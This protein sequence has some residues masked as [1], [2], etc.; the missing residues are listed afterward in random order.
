MLDDLG[1]LP[2]LIWHIDRYQEQTGLR[3]QF[4][5]SDLEGRRYPA[6]L[7]TAVY[8]IVQEALTNVA[9]HAQVKQA[10][11]SIWVETVGGIADPVHQPG[12]DAGGI[13]DPAY[14]LHVSVADR[15]VGFDLPAVRRSGEGSGLAGMQERVTLLGGRLT[16]E[17]LPG[18]G[19]HLTAVFPLSFLKPDSFA[20]E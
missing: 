20:K 9:R 2:A 16:I 5:A 11:V 15:G 12:K 6:E 13:A 10:A 1:L 4:Q 8:R 3:V 19:T 14:N 17:T 7:E 18:T